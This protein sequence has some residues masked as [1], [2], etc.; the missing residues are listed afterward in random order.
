MKTCFLWVFGQTGER[1]LNIA[2]TET[3]VAK[4]KNITL[5]MKK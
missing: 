1:N 2:V 5:V 3:Y 4:F